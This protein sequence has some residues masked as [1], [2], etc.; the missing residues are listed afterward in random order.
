VGIKRY[1]RRQKLPS[2]GETGAESASIG[3]WTACVFLPVMPTAEAALLL[4]AIG[5]LDC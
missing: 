1:G 4:S 5:F 3:N 2:T